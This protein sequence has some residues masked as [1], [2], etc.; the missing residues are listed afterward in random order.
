MLSIYLTEC[1]KKYLED[2]SLEHHEL[3]KTVVDEFPDEPAY[4]KCRD[5]LNSSARLDSLVLIS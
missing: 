1:A 2:E 5:T 3:A 4:R